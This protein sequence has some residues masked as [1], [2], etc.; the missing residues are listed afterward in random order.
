MAQRYGKANEHNG[1]MPRD[2][3]LEEWENRRSSTITTAILA[4]ATA[5]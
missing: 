1:K 5:S 4:K 3:W 2:W